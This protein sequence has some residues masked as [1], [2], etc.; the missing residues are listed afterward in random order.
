MP[1]VWSAVAGVWLALVAGPP[2]WVGAVG[3]EIESVLF[4]TTVGLG[5]GVKDVGTGLGG[6]MTVTVAVAVAVA[7]TVTVAAGVG[8]AVTRGPA[9]STTVAVAVAGLAS[10]P[11]ATSVKLRM[12]PG[13]DR[14]IVTRIRIQTACPERSWL[15]WHTARLAA[16][17]WVNLAAALRRLRTLAVIVTRCTA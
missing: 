17:Q 3:A 4:G 15:T 2:A 14:G 16:G 8:V 1:R 7:V 9:G 5:S 12:A 6:D 11:V 10:G 13:L